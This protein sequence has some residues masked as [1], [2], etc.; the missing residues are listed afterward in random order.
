VSSPIPA[1]VTYAH[2]DL[3]ALVFQPVAVAINGGDYRRGE[4]LIAQ[5]LA[6]AEQ[7]GA[8]RAAEEGRRDLE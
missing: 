4:D 5:A 7:R 3:A 6:D 8:Q 2:R 1:R